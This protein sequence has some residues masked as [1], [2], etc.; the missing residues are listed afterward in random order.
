M[1][2]LKNQ[3]KMSQKQKLTGKGT[4]K[5]TAK[6]TPKSVIHE[7]KAVITQP[8]SRQRSLMS[9]KKD[10][11]PINLQSSSPKKHPKLQTKIITYNN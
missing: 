2:G 11:N 8:P 7:Q 10:N 5:A 9:T 6:A 4:A 1:V 3:I